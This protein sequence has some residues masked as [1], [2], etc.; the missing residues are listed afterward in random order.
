MTFPEIA[1]N[2]TVLEEEREEGGLK[3]FQ[4]NPNEPKTPFMFF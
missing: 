1:R 4:T 3:N 2:V